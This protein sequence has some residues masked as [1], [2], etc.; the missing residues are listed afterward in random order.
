M[1]KVR[2]LEAAS[3]ERPRSRIMDRKLLPSGFSV[4]NPGRA[5][6]RLRV[7]PQT[8]CFFSP[9]PEIPSATQ[10]Q[11]QQQ[12]QQQQQQSH[13][14]PSVQEIV[15]W[16]EK[17]EYA[18]ANTASIAAPPVSERKSSSQS[19]VT[20]KPATPTT[21]AGSPCATV[22]PSRAPLVSAAASGSDGGEQQTDTSAT[23]EYKPLEILEYR[24]YMNNRPLG[25]CLDDYTGGDDLLCDDAKGPCTKSSG[26]ND[27]TNISCNTSRTFHLIGE[28]EKADALS[29]IG[30]KTHIEK[31]HTPSTLQIR[32]EANVHGSGGSRDNR[33][34]PN[35]PR[36]LDE[37]H[38]DERGSLETPTQSRA[39]HSPDDKTWRQQHK[40]ER[41][42]ESTAITTTATQVP[43][44]NHPPPPS[45]Q[46]QPYPQRW[47]TVSESREMAEYGRQRKL[48]EER[49]K[50]AAA[51]ARCKQCGSSSGAVAAASPTSPTCQFSRT[52]LRRHKS[53]IASARSAKSVQEKLSELNA[54][55]GGLE[56]EGEDDENRM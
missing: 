56:S 10:Q 25:R 7:K 35:V 36:R 13:T 5:S 29:F 55:L 37:K 20:C 43:A 34:A 41:P 49:E 50:K 1:D 3:K 14:G 2:S 33:H 31:Q 11:R 54:Y 6:G 39:G 47:R 19:S 22:T 21:A 51:A 52:P 40:P 44:E 4:F 48:D 28:L 17:A 53:S 18:A 42:S 46:P 24:A 23:S 26:V 12:Q 45:T 16:M 8:A 27:Q 9:S 30:T 32:R 38:G 15:R